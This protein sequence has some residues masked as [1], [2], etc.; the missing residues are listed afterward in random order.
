MKNKEW[1]VFISHASEDKES[2]VKA[3]AKSLSEIGVNVWYDEFSLKIGDSLSKK[4]DEGLIHSKYGIIVISKNF[5]SKNW[6]DYELRSLLSKEIGFKKVILPIWHDVSYDEVKN[7]SLFLADKF[8]LKSDNGVNSDLI[9][10]LL[11]VIRPDLHENLNR[12]LLFQ[13]MLKKG[14]KGLID[15]KELQVSQIRHEQ[16]PKTLLNRIKSVHLSLGK[17]LNSTYDEFVINFKRD[18][19]PTR[20]VK[21]W[22]IVNVTFLDFV[23]KNKINDDKVRSNIVLILVS[24]SLGRKPNE[25][26]IEKS[27]FEKLFKLYKENFC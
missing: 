24:L 23:N 20:E 22:E 2:F 21:V 15:I 10:K 13:K 4:I 19:N 16:L 6:T 1:D 17:Y 27:Q 11:E 7:Y 3:L 14:K 8:A 26:L 5:I 25:I 18:L 12:H 9:M